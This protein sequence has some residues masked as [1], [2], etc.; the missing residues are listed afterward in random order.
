MNTACSTCLVYT[1]HVVVAQLQ[2]RDGHR[3]VLV[4][5]GHRP[6]REQDLQGRE[7]VVVA[8]PVAE[9]VAR[10]QQLGG[11]V[12]AL[13]QGAGVLLHE[14]ALAHGGAGLLGRDRDGPLVIAQQGIA[15]SD[16]RARHHDDLMPLVAQVRDLGGQRAQPLR[17]EPPALFRERARAYLNNYRLLPGHGGT[18]P[19]THQLFYYYNI[20]PRIIKRIGRRGDV[21]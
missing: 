9:V 6:A 12:A 7:G 21:I 2:L 8:P 3:V 1:S 14:K 18:P 19:K 4:Y 11:D 16:G 15:R 13:L 20:P 17:R 10:E 5:D